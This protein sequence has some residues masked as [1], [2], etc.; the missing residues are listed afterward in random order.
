MSSLST[1]SAVFIWSGTVWTSLKHQRRED[2]ESFYWA[3][4]SAESH[5]I[6][7]AFYAFYNSGVAV[8]RHEWQLQKTTEET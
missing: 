6:S 3:A 2:G 1:A 7:D 8:D 4:V 5:P